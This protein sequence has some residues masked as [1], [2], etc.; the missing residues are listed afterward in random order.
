MKRARIVFGTTLPLLLLA[1]ALRWGDVPG[2]PERS[3]AA[4]PLLM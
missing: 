2:T 1:A 3:A 4:N